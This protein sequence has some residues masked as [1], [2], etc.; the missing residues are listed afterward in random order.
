MRTIAITTR[1]L[2]VEVVIFAAAKFDK[3]KARHDTSHDTDWHPNDQIIHDQTDTEA[4]EC[5]SDKAVDKWF[6]ESAIQ[7][8]SFRYNY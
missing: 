6:D 1:L 3:E 2:A 4:E 5:A 8:G 7:K